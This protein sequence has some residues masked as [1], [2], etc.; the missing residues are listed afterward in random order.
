MFQSPQFHLCSRPNGESW[1]PSHRTHVNTWAHAY[2]WRFHRKQPGY[3][4]SMYLFTHQYWLKNIDFTLHL[5]TENTISHTAAISKINYSTSRKTTFRWSSESGKK[6]ILDSLCQSKLDGNVMAILVAWVNFML[7]WIGKFPYLIE[8]MLEMVAGMDCLNID[9]TCRWRVNA[10]IWNAILLIST[11]HG[12]K[13]AQTV[14]IINT[15]CY[16]H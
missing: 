9:S 11:F 8:Q 6:I 14:Y 15:S 7:C 3:F 4:K 2:L 13:N 5:C 10:F 1:Q 16:R 12:E